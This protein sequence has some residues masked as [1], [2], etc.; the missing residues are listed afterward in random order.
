M[1]FLEIISVALILALP[2]LSNGLIIRLTLALCTKVIVLKVKYFSETCTMQF[3]TA[4]GTPKLW[5][6]R[7]IRIMI[8]EPGMLALVTVLHVLVARTAILVITFRNKVIV[9]Q[10]LTIVGSRLFGF[11]P[12][13]FL[14]F[15][16][17]IL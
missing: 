10:N 5:S 1:L 8:H 13:Q 2:F 9:E 11:V 16:T 14:A 3:P 12:E 15:Y 4:D 7:N 17:V 6:V